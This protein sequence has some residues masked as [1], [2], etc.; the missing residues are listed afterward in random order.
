M[1]IAEIF[2]AGAAVIGMQQIAL[3]ADLHL[4]GGMV[5]E[6]GEK[7]LLTLKKNAHIL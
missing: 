6:E 4:I 3:R 1:E 2:R 7:P 5:G